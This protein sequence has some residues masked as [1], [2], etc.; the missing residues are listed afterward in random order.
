MDMACHNE[1]LLSVLPVMVI[2]LAS[3]CPSTQQT[4]IKRERKS[5]SEKQITQIGTTSIQHAKNCPIPH[6]WLKTN[7]ETKKME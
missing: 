5:K 3:R 2:F 7:M 6:Y 4:F 1:S